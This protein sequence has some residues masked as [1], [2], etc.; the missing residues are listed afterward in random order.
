M[1]AAT[2]R[3]PAPIRRSWCCRRDGLSIALDPGQIEQ[4]LINLIRNAIE[5]L[6]GASEPR[7]VLPASR[8]VQNEILVQIIDNGVGIPAA[9]LDSIFIPFFT[10]KRNGTGV[11]LSVSWQIVQLNR[12][13]IS[14]RSIPGDG[15][16]FTLKFPEAPPLRT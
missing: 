8:N 2:F 15:C 14:V 9:H 3:G 13:L 6:T 7:I 12:G 4:V 16:I 11:G 5:A 10:T 1:S